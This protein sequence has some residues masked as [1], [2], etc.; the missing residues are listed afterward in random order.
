LENGLKTYPVAQDSRPELALFLEW[1]KIV[2]ISLRTRSVVL[3][4][5][6]KSAAKRNIK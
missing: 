1:A 6:L 3:L 2:P 5:R 4:H